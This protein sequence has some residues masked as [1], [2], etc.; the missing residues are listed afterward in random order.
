MVAGQPVLPK[1]RWGGPPGELGGGASPADGSV[2]QIFVLSY[3]GVVEFELPPDVESFRQELRS[4]LRD[5]LTDEVVAA[6]R[7]G[8]SDKGAW[9]TLREWNRRLAD[10]GWAAISWP[11]EYGGR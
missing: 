7:Q 10:A 5:N 8:P 6:G 3:L 1:F 9:A 4:W 2:D 11:A